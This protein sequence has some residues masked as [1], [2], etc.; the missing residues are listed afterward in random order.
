M[1][2]L[3]DHVAGVLGVDTHKHL[4]AVAAC[5]PT[6]G[7]IAQ[8]SAGSDEAAMGQI[9]A[10]GRTH[11]PTGRVWAVEGCGSYGANLAAFLLAHDETV[12]EVERPKRP[13]RRAHGEK[14]D[15]IDATRAARDAL[16]SDTTKLAYPK[17]GEHREALR[18][19][20]T[21]RASAIDAR[22]AALNQLHA[23]ILTAPTPLRTHLRSLKRPA[24][25]T[26]CRDLPDTDTDL[27]TRTTRTA[28]HNLAERIT[29]LTE[30]ET[31]YDTRIRHLVNHLAPTLTSQPGIGP[32][33]AAQLIISYSHHNRLRN[34]AA[35]A[36]LAGT[37]P[38]HAS[39]GQTTRTRLDR[40]GDRQLNRAL[41]T[42][43]TSRMRHDPHTRDY[44]KKRRTE[45]K[46]DREIRRCLKRYVARHCYRTLHH[47]PHLT[48][49]HP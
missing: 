30:E 19:L 37:A 35:Y 6:G 39:S 13:K 29:T 49:R 3:A 42:I 15:P 20:M 26:T 8:L 43:V 14:T 9:M 45:G 27:A 46:T 44:V 17:H 21:T 47:N 36:R 38:I 32:I 7:Q 41:H 16:G 33:S 4:H 25:L 10:F 2:M 12:V 18:V 22:K 40:G 28:L 34:E 31:S 23:L 48:P 24:L 11:I 1:P 5:R